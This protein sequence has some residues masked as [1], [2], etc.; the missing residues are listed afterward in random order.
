MDIPV[1]RVQA[2]ERKIKD[3]IKKI[4]KENMNIH[5]SRNMYFLNV[6]GLEMM[7]IK[8]DCGPCLGDYDCYSG[9]PY[10]YRKVTLGIE[11]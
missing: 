5:K 2:F 9:L 3:K 8:T 4:N 6:E 7:A 1:H 11:G 10:S